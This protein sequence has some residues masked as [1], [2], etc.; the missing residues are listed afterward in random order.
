MSLQ[1]RPDPLGYAQRASKQPQVSLHLSVD[2]GPG[3]VDDHVATV[4]HACRMDLS[5][6]RGGQRMVIEAGEKLFDGGAE[7]ML[8]HVSGLVSR[9]CRH[10]AVQPR[11]CLAIGRRQQVPAQAQTLAQLDEGGTQPHQGGAD[12]RGKPFG[13]ASAQA[14]HRDP[15]SQSGPGD[16]ASAAHRARHQREVLAGRLTM[17]APLPRAGWRS[18]RRD[19]PRPPAPLRTAGCRGTRRGRPQP[20]QPR[21]PRCCGWRTAGPA[22]P[23][24]RPG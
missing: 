19:H 10:V 24:C 17:P 3:D 16:L 21:A 7:R 9:K 8:D 15:E 18:D 6:R 22:R 20:R 13:S 5:H 14:Q 11:Q 2:A 12:V 23:V 4:M 1:R